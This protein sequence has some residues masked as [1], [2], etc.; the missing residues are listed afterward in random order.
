[1]SGAVSTA[2]TTESLHAPVSDLDGRFRARAR[3][4]SNGRVDAMSESDV[5]VTCLTT[6]LRRGEVPLSLSL[7]AVGSVS[8]NGGL[9]ASRD[10]PRT[11]P[12][13]SPR[14]PAWPTTLRRCT[15]TTRIRKPRRAVK[16]PHGASASVTPCRFVEST[17]CRALS[18]HQLRRHRDPAVLHVLEEKVYAFAG[19]RL[20]MFSAPDAQAWLSQNSREKRASHDYSLERFGSERGANDRG[21]PRNIAPVT[22]SVNHEQ[23][24][25][26]TMEKIVI[27]AW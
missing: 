26:V 22:L 9:K 13:S 14:W 4:P 27:D 5:I 17:R 7:N 3:G 2:A 18:R 15:A 8:M 16:A 12:I 25:G 24:A 1:M 21:L 19:H 11:G 10:P 6:R 23:R 20:P